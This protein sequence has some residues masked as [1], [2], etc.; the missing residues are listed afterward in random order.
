MMSK[1]RW[2]NTS[3]G[4]CRKYPQLRET[5][6]WSQFAAF[7]D[8]EERREH[9]LKMWEM[10]YPPRAYNPS[11]SDLRIY[12]DTVLGKHDIL[13]AMPNIEEDG[14]FTWLSEQEHRQDAAE[15]LAKAVLSFLDDKD[16][17]KA[18]AAEVAREPKRKGRPTMVAEAIRAFLFFLSRT[19][20]RLPTKRELDVE[21]KRISA[22]TVVSQ[23]AASCKFGDL[24]GSD[25][26]MRA[27]ARNRKPPHLFFACPGDDWNKRR[28]KKD[29]FAK[30]VLTKAG[31]TG[32]P[33]GRVGD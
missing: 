21:A 22:K 5:A 17:M 18:L 24:I 10:T 27:L 26:S 20:A 8:R 23:P 15:T 29:E 16:R 6:M 30:R 32:L 9:R 19:G 3:E 33:E 2:W 1:E 25:G 11:P 28:W 4:L 31:F 7:Y 13:M 12:A 14:T